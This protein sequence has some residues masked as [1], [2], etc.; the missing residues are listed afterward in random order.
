MIEDRPVAHV[1]RVGITW[2]NLRPECSC[3]WHG[4][5]HGGDPNPSRDLDRAA[6]EAFDHR[7]ER[8][9]IPSHAM[10]DEEYLEVLKG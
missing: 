1:V 9:G 2:G 7:C 5:L 8:M 10:T 3:N 6:Q 4:L